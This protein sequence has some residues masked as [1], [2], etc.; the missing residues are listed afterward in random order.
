MSD[1]HFGYETVDEREKAGKVREV[2]ASVARKYDVMNDLMSMGAHRAWK[3]FAIAQSGARPGMRV[4][5]VAG[6]TGD[7]A[8]AFAGKVN[9]GG[10][11]KSKPA[12]EVWLTDINGSML[13]VGRDRLTDR[14]R[15]LPVAQC[16][17]EKLPFPDEY[18]DIVSVAFGLRNMT[19]KDAALAEMGRVLRPGGRLLVL[20]FSKVWTPL[21]AP[22]D[23]YSFGILP[24]L[25]KLV[26]NDAASYQYLAESIRMH[27]DQE[28]LKG[29]MLNAGF[30][31]ADYFN[32][33][34]GVVA[35][36]RGFKY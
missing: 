1:T 9:V 36:H 16:D 24:R 13:G 28:T 23:A 18:F 3:A 4:L 30:D 6:G 31:R 25:G 33:T 19:H 34:A 2:F 20:E 26:A 10:A 21:K 5:D 35:L 15:I 29:M 11:D 17:A 22:Y 14:G 32:L 8:Y 27:P 12:G 7:L